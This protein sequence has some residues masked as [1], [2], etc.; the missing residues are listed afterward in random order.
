MLAAAP[1]H[2]GQPVLVVC[3]RRRRVTFAGARD[4]LGIEVLDL[5]QLIAE[6]LADADRLAA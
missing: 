6:R 1:A 5:L 3:P 4:D 2:L